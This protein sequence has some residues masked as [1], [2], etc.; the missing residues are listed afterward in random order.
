MSPFLRFIL[1]FSV[2]IAALWMGWKIARPGSNITATSASETDAKPVAHATNLTSGDPVERLRAGKTKAGREEIMGA[3]MTLGHERNPAMLIEALKDESVELRV[4][5]VEYAAALTPAESALVLREA[6]LNDN[7]EVR[8]K[9]WSL[10]APHPLEN[11]VPVIISTIERG[12]DVSL[13]E[14]FSEMGRTPERPLF[15]T[16]LAAAGRAPTA[17]QT[18]VLRELQEWLKPGGGNVPAFQSA[19]QLNTW[20]ETNKKNYD[21]FMLR[22]DL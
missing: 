1:L 3:F 15:D 17:R 13:E 7:Q 2:L 22:V 21:Q 9:G 10:L 4:Q 5:A 18:R 20:W 12:S 11:K 8:D 16:M 14:L 19:G 6:V